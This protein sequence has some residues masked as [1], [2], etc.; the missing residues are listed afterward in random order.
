MILSFQQC[1]INSIFQVRYL[2]IGVTTNACGQSLWWVAV[3]SCRLHDCKKLK[4][5]GPANM[6]LRDVCPNGYPHRQKMTMT[7]NNGC[8]AV[9][10]M[11]CS[12]CPCGPNGCNVSPPEKRCSCTFQ[13][14]YTY[15]P[16]VTE[17]PNFTPVRA[18]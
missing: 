3:E 4:K 7:L 17:A 6:A 14:V 9:E 8:L 13:K 10:C 16:G 12:T 11:L 18:R 15:P 5:Y 2:S 1:I